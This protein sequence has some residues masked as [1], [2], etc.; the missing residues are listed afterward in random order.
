MSTPKIHDLG[1]SFDER[2]VCLHAA[3]GTISFLRRFRRVLR[4][5][6]SPGTKLGDEG[7]R[8]SDY[9]EDPILYATLGLIGFSANMMRHLPATKAEASGLRAKETPRRSVEAPS[10]HAI[11]ELLR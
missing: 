3:L 7:H 4:D 2:N 9:E 5:H 10:R 1:N 11:R 6:V 8:E